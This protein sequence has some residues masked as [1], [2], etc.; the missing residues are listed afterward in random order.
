MEAFVTP[1]DETTKL[2]TDWLSEN[3]ISTTKISPAGDWLGFSVTAQ[4]AGELLDTEF[5]TFQH[6]DSGETSIRTMAY[7]VPADLADHIEL[8]HPT[9]TYVH[10]KCVDV[11]TEM[12]N[13]AR[14]LL[15]SRLR[16]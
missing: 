11:Q 1:T 10:P 7:S 3:K 4:Q 16:E 13:C 6:G 12:L 14:S 9:I 15:A 5:A 8:V 2:V